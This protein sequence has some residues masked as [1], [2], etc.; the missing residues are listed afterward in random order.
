MGAVALCAAGLLC[1]PDGVRA[2]APVPDCSPDV[3]PAFFF[4]G[5]PETLVYGR[6]ASWDLE[7]DLAPNSGTPVDFRVR[8]SMTSVDRA[9][10]VRNTFSREY[11]W[12][13]DTEGYRLSFRRGEGRARVT[14]TWLERT[15]SGECRRTITRVVTPKDPPPALT[16]RAP[17]RQDILKQVGVRLSARCSSRC[18]G[19]FTA[20]LIYRGRAYSA[21]VPVQRRLPA[22]RTTTM[23]LTLSAT[24]LS[25]LRRAQAEGRSWRTRVYGAVWSP[26]VAAGA[27]WT[28]SSRV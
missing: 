21:F 25:V 11:R 26:G 16:L 23:K 13:S 14:A 17:L 15:E 6:V 10:P 2:Q 7:L 12:S 9:R 28:A 19:R 20:T 5:L 27:A 4:R 24:G 3:K 22:N 1:W 18:T 8:V